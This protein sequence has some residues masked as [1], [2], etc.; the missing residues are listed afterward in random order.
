MCKYVNMYAYSRSPSPLPV[1]IS[2][3]NLLNQL[4]LNA[5]VIYG[6]PYVGFLIVAITAVLGKIFMSLLML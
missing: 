5:Y 3:Q 2:M 1:H 6:W 4:P